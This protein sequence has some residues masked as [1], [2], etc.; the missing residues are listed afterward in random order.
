MQCNAIK[1]N[2]IPSLPPSSTLSLLNV[3]ADI[4][5]A[6]ALT[7]KLLKLILCIKVIYEK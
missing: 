5:Y 1:I 4:L 7:L 6:S 3:T 2:F